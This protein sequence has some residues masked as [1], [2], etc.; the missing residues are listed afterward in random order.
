MALPISVVLANTPAQKTKNTPRAPGSA[1]LN[2]EWSDQIVS[3]PGLIANVPVLENAAAGVGTTNTLPEIDGVNRR[4]P[5]IVTVDDKLYPSLAMETMRVATGN[6]TF[7]VK[8]FEGGVE[9]MRL[10]GEVGIISTDNLGRV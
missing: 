5:L 7:Q 10:P 4:M 1:V 6:D 2:P 9:K 8:L 3:Y